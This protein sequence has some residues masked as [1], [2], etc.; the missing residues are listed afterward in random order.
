MPAVGNEDMPTRAVAAQPCD[1]WA[2]PFCCTQP[3]LNACCFPLRTSQVLAITEKDL[4]P[5]FVIR[6]GIRYLLSQRKKE[7]RKDRREYKQ[8]SFLYTP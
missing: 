5:D 2:V 1:E 6:T 8:T 4:V 3:A 7:V